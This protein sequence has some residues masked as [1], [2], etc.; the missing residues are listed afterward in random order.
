[1]NIE[2]IDKNSYSN[3]LY[4]DSINEC[5]K[6]SYVF[7]YDLFNSEFK[8]IIYDQNPIF[9][10]VDDKSNKIDMVYIRVAENKYSCKIF[11]PTQ[12]QH[13]LKISAEKRQFEIDFVIKNCSK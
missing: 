4:L 13:Y 7:C 12:G 11:K 1:M 10:L 5:K 8:V 9:A 6:S 3:V 2:N